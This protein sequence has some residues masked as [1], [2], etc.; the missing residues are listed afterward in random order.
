[1]KD[2]V[3][4]GKITGAGKR[5]STVLAHDSFQ[6][7]IDENKGMVPELNTRYRDGWINAHWQP[8]FRS[9]SGIPWNGTEH[10]DFWKVSLLY[11]IAGNFPCCPNFGPDNSTVDYDFPPHGFTALKSW[12]QG[13]PE[14]LP[15]NRG[16][17]FMSSLKAE[18]HPFLYRKTDMVLQGQNV[19]YTRLEVTNTGD[20]REPYNCAWHNTVGPPFLESGCIIDNNSTSFQTIPEGT[21]F[22]PT[23]RLA[24][25]AKTDSLEKVPLKDGRTADLRIVPGIIGFSD[26]ITGAVPRNTEL[27]W[28]SV[29]NPRLKLVYLSFFTGPKAVQSNELPLYFY[30][31]WMNYGGRD[32]QPW[33]AADGHPDQTFCLGPENSTGYFANGLKDALENKSLMGNPSFLELD[34][35][36]SGSLYYGT[37]FMEYEGNILDRGVE[38]VEPGDGAL[39]LKGYGGKS[40]SVKADWNF[41]ILKQL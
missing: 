16:E 33:A 34:S 31:L 26:F 20:V 21:E 37:L 3:K 35:G 19:H 27:G 4:S 9:N 13:V 11:D 6:V 10:S 14:V 18:E 7:V 25:G 39:I 8:W 5:N 15:E 32:F 36:A 40:V 30:N 41:T 17:F 23:G 22:D 28:S 38:S 29:V 1:M 24:F 12:S 2:S